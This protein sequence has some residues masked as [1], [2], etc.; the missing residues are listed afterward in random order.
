[1]ASINWATIAPES[2]LY[3]GKNL[4]RW[5][6]SPG[7][8]HHCGICATPLHNSR[9]KTTCIGKHVEPCYRFH[10]QLHFVGK[11]HEC[12]GCNTSDEMHH[13][14]HKDILKI[15]RQISAIDGATSINLCAKIGMQTSE[16]RG[17]FTASITTSPTETST[18]SVGGD[19]KTT[20]KARKK[21]KKAGN[22]KTK[23]KANVEAFP[24]EEV[25]F[26]SESIHLTILES[27]GA[28]EGTYVYSSKDSS[29]CSEYN[30][31][32]IETEV[33]EDEDVEDL[34]VE[35]EDFDGI[36][37]TAYDMTPR[38]RK[39]A[40]FFTAPIN[41][42][43]FGGGSRK[44]APDSVKKS[45][46]YNGVD[47]QIFVR[48]GVEIVNPLVNSKARKELA[49]K[50]VAAIKD[51]LD[52][53]Y[54]EDQ[55]TEMRKEGFIRWAGKTALYHMENTRQGIDWATGQKICPKLEDC[56]LETKD[57]E[58]IVDTI[59]D[60]SQGGAISL[61]ALADSLET[62]AEDS[63]VKVPVATPNKLPVMTPTLRII[64]GPVKPPNTSMLRV[65]DG[66]AKRKKTKTP[67]F[68]KEMMVVTKSS[69][70]V[71]GKPIIFSQ[72]VEKHDPNQINMWSAIV[73]NDPRPLSNVE[74]TVRVTTREVFEDIKPAVRDENDDEWETVVRTKQRPQKPLKPAKP[75]VK[76]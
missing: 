74:N 43:S 63:V 76:Y 33:F 52:I 18:E 44:Y 69:P 6:V 58:D 65:V 19:L 22:N 16:R 38:Q 7:L 31:E 48:L 35:V 51:D 66:P 55:E 71:Y 73:Q 62:L 41:Y 61:S 2:R 37:K 1:M 25:D 11:S 4:F 59:K 68:G 29:P 3:K 46:L 64:A 36:V 60:S 53:I 47:P 56:A 70:R 24:R 28:W 40:K 54:R 9:A 57:V 72:L 10:Q 26:I 8:E 50:L 67:S 15:L 75:I 27:K 32:G 39:V 17:S 49:T 42:S 20:R 34:L 5:E 30:N 12:F 14:R 13:N 23:N 21:A 45:D